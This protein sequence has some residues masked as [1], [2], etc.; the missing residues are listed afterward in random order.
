MAKRRLHF[1]VPKSLVFNL[2]FLV[3][4]FLLVFVAYTLFSKE[5]RLDFLSN[6]TATIFGV[7]VGI[8]IAL[9]ISEFQGRKTEI[10]SKEKILKLL[11][12]EMLLNKNELRQ[13]IDNSQRWDETGKLK[14]LLRNECWLAFSDGGE[15][16]NIKDSMLLSRL[17]NFY[18]SIRSVMY[19]TEKY[20]DLTMFAGEGISTYTKTDLLRALEKAV[21]DALSSYELAQGE[22]QRGS[23]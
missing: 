20:Y 4:V 16:E 2:I 13:W 9:F 5:I 6:T 12:D 3:I 11:K 22:I 14:A 19:L 21:Y 18:Y 1:Y 10:E 7:V 23:S 15:L 17:A 8:P